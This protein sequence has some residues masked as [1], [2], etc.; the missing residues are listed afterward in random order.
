MFQV[1]HEMFVSMIF[2][3]KYSCKIIKKRGLNETE[4]CIKQSVN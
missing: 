4:Q 2:N 1:L 3:M